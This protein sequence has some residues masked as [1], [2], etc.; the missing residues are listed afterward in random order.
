M[1]IWNQN[2]LITQLQYIFGNFSFTP[3]IKNNV[4]I[5]FIFI[6]LILLINYANAIIMLIMAIRI[7]NKNIYIILLIIF[8][9]YD[10][11]ESK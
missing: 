11:L 9:V 6:C 3:L 10:N 4:R 2:E 1:T 5:Y 8:I 7:K